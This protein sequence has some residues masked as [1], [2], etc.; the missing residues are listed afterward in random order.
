MKRLFVFGCSFT[1]WAWPTW[2]D[3]LSFEFD[4]YE[5]WGEP[6]IGNRA[7]AEKVAECHAKNN[8][9][10]NDTVIIQWSSYTRFDWYK[11][12]FNNIEKTHEG[13]EVHQ[14]SE[15][16]KKYKT[17]FEKTYSEKAYVMH[18]LNMIVLVKS[19]L[20]STDCIWFMTSLSDIRNLGYDSL[21]YDRYNQ[22]DHLKTEKLIKKSENKTGW[23]IYDR[24]PE[25]EIYNDMLWNQNIKWVS[26]M[27]N[28]IKENKNLL[29]TFSK[30]RYVEFHPTPRQHN[31][32]LEKNFDTILSSENNFKREWIIEKF[33][34]L[35]NHDDYSS[36]MFLFLA[37]ELMKKI[38]ESKYSKLQK[39]KLGF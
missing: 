28:N 25:F 19:L 4:Y 11:D 22:T 30:D 17:L 20:S 9:S 31:I 8:F 26:P 21:F 12:V 18:T 13:W 36:S 15:Y 1:N 6:G 29:W 32:W 14:D 7:I 23:I 16:Y 2:A 39:N 27:F 10:K 38:A 3:L 35:K 33:E 37:E 5:N 34:K 24:F